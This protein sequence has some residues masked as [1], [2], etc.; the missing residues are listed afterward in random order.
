MNEKT[1]LMIKPG[2]GRLIPQILR[3][4][5][6]VGLKMT[7]WGKIILTESQ[8]RELY[9]QDKGKPWWERFIVYLTSGSVW[10]YVISGP[11][12]FQET[13]FLRAQ[14][15]EKYAIN[16]MQNVIHAPCRPTKLTRDWQFFV[17]ALGFPKEE[18][19]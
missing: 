2:F 12:A 14:I 4:A 11:N 10:V 15:R 18:D 5:Q 17:Q 8:A 9:S 19:I 7:L 13:L 1:V 6:E 3:E 16:R